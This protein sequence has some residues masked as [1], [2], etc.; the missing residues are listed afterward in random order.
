[1]SKN[2]IV[3]NRLPVQINQEGDSFTITSSS[4]G[5]AT[6]MKSVHQEGNSLWVGWSGISEEAISAPSKKVLVDSL[7][8]ERYETVS[9]DAQEIEDFY[10]GL[11]N[12][13]LWPLFHYF[14]EFSIFDNVQWESYK[15]VNQ[16]FADSVLEHLE[17]GDKV[18]IHDYQLLLCPQM[19]KAVHPEVTIGFF[20]HIPFPSFEIF[21]IF[22]WRAEL[23]NGMLGA[24][25]KE[26]MS[27]SCHS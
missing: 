4:G 27:P 17:E 16:K 13:S 7:R 5:L 26:V 8:K 2:I 20:L 14:T 1:M 15:K 25:L 10:Y 24:D 22:P 12:K 19:I 18:W 21:Q 23:L 11:S 9:L 3:S 6:G